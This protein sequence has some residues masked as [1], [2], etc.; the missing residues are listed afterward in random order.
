MNI[1]IKKLKDHPE[2]ITSLVDIWHKGLGHWLPEVTLQEINQWYQ[3]WTNDTLPMA[4]VAFDGDIPA[5]SFSLQL[6]DGVRPDLSPW[7]GDLIVSEP[8]RN[9]GIGKLLI[10]HAMK[11]TK[12]MGFSRL[13]LFTFD[14]ELINFYSKIGW[15]IL[16]SDTYANRDVIIMNIALNGETIDE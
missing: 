6:N 10:K 14:E 13:Y 3:E 4:Y 11:K 5:A 9:C 16:G 8:Y 15:S 1:I 7:L 12:E 2:T